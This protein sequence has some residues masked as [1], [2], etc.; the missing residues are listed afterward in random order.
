MGAKMFPRNGK[1]PSREIM[2]YYR[3]MQEKFMEWYKDQSQKGMG[4]RFDNDS[5][6]AGHEKAVTDF[7]TEGLLIN[8][9]LAKSMADAIA[10]GKS[11]ML[12]YE[13]DGIIKIKN[14]R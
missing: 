9:E 7:M 12:I 8:P 3:M 4:G 14:I 6:R 1:G 11:E 10:F 5:F 2:E 13:E